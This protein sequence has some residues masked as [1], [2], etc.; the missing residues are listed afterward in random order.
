MFVNRIS[1]RTLPATTFISELGL[2]PTR[3]QL[4][5]NLHIYPLIGSSKKSMV[6]G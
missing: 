5:R 3:E 4:H 1:V 6:V 2:E